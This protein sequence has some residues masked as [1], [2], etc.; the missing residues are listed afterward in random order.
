PNNRS[1]FW[2][3][4]SKQS[5]R[6]SLFQVIPGVRM[7]GVLIHLTFVDVCKKTFPNTRLI[8]TRTQSMLSIVPTIKV[9]D[10]RYGTRIG[11]PN[12]K[13][14]SLLSIHGGYMSAH[15]LI[16]LKMLTGFKQVN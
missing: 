16:Q 1:C 8:P 15:F 9:S 3:H 2:R 4:F 6:I 10:Y 7:N 13:V 5:K 12:G 14:S 11:C